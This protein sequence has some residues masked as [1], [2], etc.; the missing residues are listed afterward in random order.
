MCFENCDHALAE[1]RVIV[2]D[3]YSNRARGGIV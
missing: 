1:E 2:R 3:E